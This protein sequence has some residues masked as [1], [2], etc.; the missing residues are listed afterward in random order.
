VNLVPVSEG[1]SQQEQ[2]Q[3]QQQQQQHDVHATAVPPLPI[4]VSYFH[5]Y[6]YLQFGNSLVEG[7]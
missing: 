1:Q 4:Q 2:Q 7:E 6:G 5:R 3:Q